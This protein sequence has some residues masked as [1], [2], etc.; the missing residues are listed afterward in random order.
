MKTL[1]VL[2]HAKSEHPPGVTDFDRSLN[3]RGKRDALRVGEV[4]LERGLKP[5][6]I[7]SSSA[8]RA[9]KTAGRVAGTCDYDRDII[10]TE[11]LYEAGPWDIIT[12]IQQI[13][14]DAATALIVGHNPGF[15][16]VTQRL[17]G[18]IGQFPTAAWAHISLPVEVWGEVTEMTRG[19]L[20]EL[21]Y[22]K[23]EQ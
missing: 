10:E 20:V 1:I 22:P 5:D 15:W 7:V 6:V 17:G 3:D 4:L 8:R 13:P 14:E 21:W 11:D 12:V 23:I 9:R 2:R 18:S 16:S 19:E